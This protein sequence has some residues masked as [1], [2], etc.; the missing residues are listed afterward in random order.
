M[1]LAMTATGVTPEIVLELLRMIGYI[2]RVMIY[3]DCSSS[4][5]NQANGHQEQSHFK[6][7]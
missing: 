7:L 5:A 6:Y 1:G 2:Y 4:L 3:L